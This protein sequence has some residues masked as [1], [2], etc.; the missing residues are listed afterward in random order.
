MYKQPYFIELT[1]TFH[2]SPLHAHTLPLPPHTRHNVVSAGFELSQY[3]G[4]EGADLSVRLSASILT[5]I[6][7]TFG[8][9]IEVDVTA[10]DLAG[11]AIF[12]KQQ[13]SICNWKFYHKSPPSCLYNLIFCIS[14]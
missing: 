3:D 5:S 6:P 13:F 9:S 4:T 1:V 8:G 11:G 2:H 7:I 14:T 10:E 12:G